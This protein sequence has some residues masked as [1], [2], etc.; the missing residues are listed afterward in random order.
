MAPD[1]KKDA[2]MGINAF[3]SSGIVVLGLI[4]SASFFYYMNMARDIS[5][6]STRIY[7]AYLPL[8]EALDQVDRQ[9]KDLWRLLGEVVLAESGTQS[10][11]DVQAA[12]AQLRKAPPTG[13]IV[14]RQHWEEAVNALERLA[15]LHAPGARSGSR[16]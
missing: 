3:L 2:C 10:R 8:A 14:Q 6:A 5:V 12:I 4:F 7:G 13:A 1:D 16:A 15:V 11:Q 9:K